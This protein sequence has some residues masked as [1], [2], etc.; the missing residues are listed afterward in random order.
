MRGNTNK[1]PGTGVASAT[2]RRRTDRWVY[3][4]HRCD[5]TDVLYHALFESA[6]K[7][8]SPGSIEQLALHLS[9]RAPWIS[10]GESAYVWWSLR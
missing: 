7:R 4:V 5:G 3:G 8:L 6:F 9:K 2:L 1:Q 10:G